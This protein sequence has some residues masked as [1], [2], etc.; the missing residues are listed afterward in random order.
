MENSTTGMKVTV[1]QLNPENIKTE[2]I[3]T[4]VIVKALLHPHLKNGITR[5]KEI[6]MKLNL[7]KFNTVMKRI[8]MTTKKINHRNI[9]P[10]PTRMKATI[11]KINR[12]NITT[13]MKMKETAM[14]LVN[15]EKKLKMMLNISHGAIKPMRMNATIKDISIEE[16]NMI[17]IILMKCMMRN[18][19][20]IYKQ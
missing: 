3:Q 5:K 4:K 15:T 9:N 17:T 12:E 18:S 19:N 11:T 13:K 20:H 16:L 6:V 1:M 10:L 14:S 2:H 7:V 8:N